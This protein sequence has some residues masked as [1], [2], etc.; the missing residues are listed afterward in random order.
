[1]AATVL[2]DPLEILAEDFKEALLRHYSFGQRKAAV[3]IGKT[4]GDCP[5]LS[6]LLENGQ[7]L[8][9]T[10]TRAQS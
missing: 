4:N 2:S 5:V 7:R 8:H 10:V 9:L 3:S 6:V 1:M